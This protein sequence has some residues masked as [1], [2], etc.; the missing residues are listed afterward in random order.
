MERDKFSFRCAQCE[1]PVGHPGKD[2]N[3]EMGIYT[4]LQSPR[5]LFPSPYWN[6]WRGV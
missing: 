4:P 6:L 5:S 2:S 3:T 1:M